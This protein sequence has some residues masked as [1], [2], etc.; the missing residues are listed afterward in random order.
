MNMYPALPVQ[1]SGAKHLSNLGA[2]GAM[3][4]SLPVLPPLVEDNYSS[5]PGSFQLSSERELMRNPIS[6]QGSLVA[7]NSN[8]DGQLFTSPGF[9]NDI[10][11]SSV[12]PRGRHSRNSPFISQSS[13]EG[14][15]FPSTH[16]SR[17]DVQ[18]TALISQ[19]DGTQD[20]SWCTNRL[21]DFL[22]FPENVPVENIQVE[23]ST[24]AVIPSEDHA[25]R[26]DWQWV[27]GLISEMDPD[28]NELP[29]VSV[30]DP[31]LEQSQIH[32]PQSIASGELLSVT[33]TLTTQPPTKSRMRWTPELHESFVRAVN[34]L[35][36]SERAT[37]KGV[38]NIM[39]HEGLTI[40]HVKSHLQKYRTARYKPESSEGTSEKKVTPIEDVKSVDL[41][42]SMGITEALR[43]QMELQKRLHEQLENQRKLQL[44][45]EQQGQ[46]L[47]MMLERNIED[48][49]IRASTSAADDH[50][51]PPSRVN[52]PSLI[53]RKSETSNIDQVKAEV[54]I[55]NVN[56]VPEDGSWDLK[57][58]EREH[59]TQSSQ[60][61]EP[62]DVENNAPPTK[63][64]RAD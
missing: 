60:K 51:A 63:R 19:H 10:H 11:F 46:K 1:R 25:G 37:P 57:R 35:G 48:N 59:E 39:K 20:I 13:A 2:S 14:A 58:K 38:R 50:S 32:Q 15:S 18:S 6:V 41:K 45:I 31:K 16:S 62:G 33:S 9:V 54:G 30:A 12:S 47:Q 23:S 26:N 5:F 3:S 42:T 55:S 24:T 34:E 21:Q 56:T 52:Q 36:G 22:N 61:Q 8:I 7:S 29:D 43:L 28:W 27:D 40:Y 44:Q 17:L 53:D 64:V 49:R 4:S